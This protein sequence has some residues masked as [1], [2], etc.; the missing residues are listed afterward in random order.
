MLEEDIRAL[1]AAIEELTK[2]VRANTEA[3]VQPQIDV[4]PG[5]VLIPPAGPG[6]VVEEK[7]KQKKTRKKKE[8]APVPES[9]KEA[10]KAAPVDVT[11]DK[12]KVAASELVKAAPKGKGVPAAKAILAE[13][14]IDKLD[15]TP[16]EKFG[17]VY[18]AFTKERDKWN[19]AK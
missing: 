15:Q 11:M 1:T 18:T 2:W 12:L 6:G 5:A 19:T 9:V 3:G 7:P 16:E 14:G 13:L 8:A 17:D 10:A 4:T